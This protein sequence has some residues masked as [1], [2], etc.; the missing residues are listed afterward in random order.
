[1]RKLKK[2][3][4]SIRSLADM[5]SIKRVPAE[6]DKTH[7]LETTTSETIF[8]IMFAGALFLCTAKHSI[9]V[10]RSCRVENLV[11]KLAVLLLS[12]LSKSEGQQQPCWS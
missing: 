11:L 10:F 2:S 6:A 1:M 12:I 5:K 4:Q 7:F 8:Q 3:Q 9:I